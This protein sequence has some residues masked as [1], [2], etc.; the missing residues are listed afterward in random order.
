MQLLGNLGFDFFELGQLGFAHVVH[1][2]DVKAKL[3][4][5][6]GIGHLTFVQFDHGT[7]KLGHVAAGCSPVEVATVGTGAWVFGG[8][9]GQVFKA[10]AFFDLGNQGQGF[11]FFFNQD[12]AGA[13]FLATIGCHKF[14]VL[15]LDV[16]ICD[17]VFLLEV[18][19]Q[20]A[21][22]DGLA[23]QFDLGFVLVRGVQAA[24]FGFLHEHFAGDQ[25]FLDLGQHFGCHG[26]A[27]GFNLLLERIHARR[28][29]WLAVDHS[30]V[31]R[32][33]GNRQ[34]GDQG[35]A[36]H[37]LF[38]FVF[39]ND[40]VSGLNQGFKKRGCHQWVT[41]RV[42]I[43]SMA[44]ACRPWSMKSCSASYTRRWR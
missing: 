3:A 4:L 12:V 6:G 24:L 36:E 5:D 34:Q 23:G 26:A 20:L 16:S 40:V 25:L 21:D 29:H 38:H 35:G 37:L 8:F 39:L 1:T 18:G 10:A 13:V 43:S 42:Q 30:Q 44:R 31:L 9:F 33:G 15:T 7:R 41:A 27:R 32:Q 22:Q 19:K 2:D 11:V 28:R 17:R 14:V